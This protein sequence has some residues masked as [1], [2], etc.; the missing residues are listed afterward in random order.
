MRHFGAL[1][2]GV[3]EST[4]AFL[5]TQD[6]EWG[7]QAFWLLN[8]IQNDFLMHSHYR[9]S[10]TLRSLGFTAATLYVAVTAYVSIVQRVRD[11]PQI[12]LESSPERAYLIAVRDIYQEVA[13]L[14]RGL[15]P[16]D[17]DP[18]AQ[19]GQERVTSID[20]RMSQLC[21]LSQEFEPGPCI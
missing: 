3:S 6:V 1:L 10:E 15:E 14:T 16:I 19:L 12:L 7:T 4:D 21:S 20:E 11:N 9:E 5:E 18:L 2:R 8:R 17:V 13:D